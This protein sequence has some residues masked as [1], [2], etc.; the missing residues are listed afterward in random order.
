M[1]L[2]VSSLSKSYY[3][4]YALTNSDAYKAHAVDSS[5]VSKS[6]FNVADVS[7]A[8]DMLSSES[9]F[10]TIGSI[11]SYSKDLYKLSQIKDTSKNDTLI[12]NVVSLFSKDTDMFSI[13]DTSAANA[14]KVKEALS[15]SES[16]GGSQKNNAISA[17]TSFVSA[18][19]RFLENNDQGLISVLL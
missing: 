16:T 5:A 6:K 12:N 4:I 2:T 8:F 10:S 19:T 3:N 7:S 18:Y 1:S 17:Y 15:S 11:S 13:L 14:Q 9:N